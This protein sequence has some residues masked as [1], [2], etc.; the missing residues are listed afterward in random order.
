MKD[1]PSVLE[2]LQQTAQKLSAAA[3][4]E[5]GAAKCR[6]QAGKKE[7]AE[8]LAGVESQA[9]EQSGWAQVPARALQPSPFA[10]EPFM[11]AISP[12]Q[13]AQAAPAT[14]NPPCALSP[15]AA[16]PAVLAAEAAPQPSEE[17]PTAAAVTKPASMALPASPAGASPASARA[18]SPAA[19][20]PAAQLALFA[21]SPL[22]LAA[23]PAAEAAMENAPPEPLSQMAPWSPK[24]APA[25]QR[26]PVPA[27]RDLAL[28]SLPPPAQPD[29]GREEPAEAAAA[30][31]EAPAEEV[32]QASIAAS[33]QHVAAAAT[34]VWESA[35]AP[36]S[37][38]PPQQAAGPLQPPATAP[39]LGRSLTRQLV[40][41]LAAQRESDQSP[42]LLLQASAAL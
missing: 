9:Q 39:V 30:P 29:A 8:E 40:R 23:E 4:A 16:A 5:A 26:S 33:E 21:G 11:A 22:Q 19:P 37:P 2:R 32:T 35:S 24:S 3:Q 36:V 15:G 14:A 7:E 42:R 27:A 25:W 17:A 13:S 31:Y 1:P 38:V 34:Q 6:Q 28:Q 18:A 12:L 41:T 10:G 20:L